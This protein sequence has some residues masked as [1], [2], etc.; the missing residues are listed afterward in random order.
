M[1]T[2]FLFIVLGILS[3]SHF[4]SQHRIYGK[5]SDQSGEALAGATVVI[6]G[7][8]AGKVANDQGNYSL[9][10]LL[11]GEYTLAVKFIGFKP[12]EKSVQLSGSDLNLDFQLEEENVMMDEFNAIAIKAKSSTPTAFTNLTKEDIRK[13]NFGQ[14]LPYLLDQTPSTVVTSDAGAGVG[15]TGVRIRGV[16]P[17]RTN[18]TVNGI[19][20]NDAESHG[21]FWVNMPDFASSVSGMQIQRGVGTSTNGAAAFGASI[22]IQTNEVEA[23]PYAILD[24]AAGSFNTLRNTVK[25]GT[26]LIDGKF[27][28]DGRLSR[29]T[30]GGYIDRASSDLKSFYLSGAWMGKKSSLRAN[31]FSGKERTYQAWYGTPESRIDGDVDA[32]NAY[33]D[34]NWLTDEEREN[35][36]NSGRTYNYYTYQN[37]V[38][39]YQQDHYQLHFSHR[40]NKKW[41][42]NIA[43]HYTY[44][45]GYYEQ[46]KVGEDL[47][48]YG[49]D[50]IYLTSD[51]ITSS[52]IIRRRWLD[53]H[54]YGGVY[55]INF[56]NGGLDLTLGGAGNYYDGRH[57][58]EVIWAEFASNSELG[59]IYYDNNASKLELNSYLKA[60]YTKG[61]FTA[62]GDIQ[63]RNISYQFIGLN[64]VGSSEYEGPQT[65]DYTFLNPKIGASY[66]VG[67]NGLMYASLCVANREP[68]RND[69]VE[70]TPSS[71]PKPETLRDF[72]AGYRYRSN[73][74]SANVNLYHMN[75][76]NQLILTGQINDVGAYTRTNVDASYRSGIELEI[77][78]Q[79]HKKLTINFNT[80]LSQNKIPEFTEYID[81]YDNGGQVAIVHHNVDLGFSPN[82]IVGGSLNYTPLKNLTLS[83]LPKYVGK[84]YLD[85]TQD[86]N[87]A[88]DSYFVTHVRAAYS[89][90]NII[91]KELNFA[92]QVNNVGNY[93]YEN[94]GYTFSYIYGSETITENFYYPQAGR[95]FMAS[96][97]LKF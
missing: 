60:N 32:M 66:N 38:D 86:E 1:K 12:I 11:D 54:F 63:V 62:F 75:Y 85:N 83:V 73:K 89:L 40:F 23:Q 20:I 48:D 70:S 30:S 13:A 65:A 74:L 4:F 36:L 19:P 3:C 35:L 57:Y 96:L 91:G 6:E 71:R 72:E 94:N 81:D 45:R 69:F 5:I 53:N 27:T 34:R 47:A 29:I 51:T 18:V 31:V 56:S 33:A 58:G 92:V 64:D 61:N 77:G 9:D 26:G 2:R 78:Y 8:Y 76:K 52:D 24:N 15:Y 43:A 14:D 21:V 68:V 42:A 79:L 17:T 16:D 97:F 55:S 28:V 50:Y 90:K 93:L 87:R 95:N 44:G 25:V 49:F 82:T 37:E 80:T 46:F 41:N 39:N 84:Q 10:H 59:T 22:N 67:K 88:M 7:T